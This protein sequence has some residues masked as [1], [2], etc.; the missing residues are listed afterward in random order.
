MIIY[1][2]IKRNIISQSFG[3]NKSPRYKEADMKGHNGIDWVLKE[4]DPI[5]FD[6]DCAGI[7]V[8]NHI[9]SKGGLGVVII[10]DDKDGLF[11][12]RY[13]HLKQFHAKVGQRVETGDLLGWGDNTGMSTGHHLH[14][15]MKRLEW[16][17]GGTNYKIQDYKNGYFGG[18][19]YEPFLENIFV[20]KKM[21]GLR[22]TKTIA[23]FWIKVVQLKILKWKLFKS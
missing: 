20:L 11:K 5:Y 22:L 9:D 16:W 6:C 17:S 7:V 19:D 23:E 3:Q 12:H 14:R 15:D 4:G 10:T 21:K 18:I 8:E 2:A 13:W 1:R